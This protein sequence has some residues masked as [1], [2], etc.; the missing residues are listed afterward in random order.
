VIS[1]PGHSLPQ[2]KFCNE[3]KIINDPYEIRFPYINPKSA[4]LTILDTLFG[5]DNSCA[6][7]SFQCAV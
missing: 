3:E 2:Y 4:A 1:S 6:S 7:V 5:V